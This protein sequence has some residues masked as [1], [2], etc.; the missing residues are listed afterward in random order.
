MPKRSLKRCT[1]PPRS[2]L[3]RTPVQAGWVLGSISRRSERAFLAPGRLRLEGRAVGHDHGDLVVVG[4]DLLF[5]R[6][7]PAL[8]GR[9]PTGRRDRAG[10]IQAPPAGDK[11]TSN[12]ALGPLR[13]RSWGE[14]ARRAGGEVRRRHAI[15][16]LR[17]RHLTLPLLRNGPRPL[18][19]FAAERSLKRLSPA[20]RPCRPAGLMS[21][22]AF[23]SLANSLLAALE[24][25]IGAHADAELQ[26]GDSDR[27]RR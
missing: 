24:E 15:S 19:R 1:R 18:P 20:K 26:G 17:E 3:W 5:H 2:M 16:R 27:R 7:S 14:R 13:P 6:P 11:P 10:G 4:V 12:P 25:G 21:D 8:R 23:E 9:F 22:S